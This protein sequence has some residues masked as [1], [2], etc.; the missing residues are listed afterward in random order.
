MLFLAGLSCVI[1]RIPSLCEA[2]A[3]LGSMSQELFLLRH[4]AFRWTSYYI[5]DP[6]VTMILPTIATPI[7]PYTAY[8]IN[9]LM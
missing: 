4:I 1:Y 9:R 3:P 2:I 5:D 8:G 7:V 6:V